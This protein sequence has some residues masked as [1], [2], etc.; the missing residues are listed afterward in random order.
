MLR[1][2]ILFLFCLEIYS[3]SS[4][5][6]YSHGN[7]TPL[8]QYYLEII[9]QTRMKSAP[10]LAF[11]PSLLNA[12]QKHAKDMVENNYLSHTNR[13]RKSPTDRAT[14]EGY[15][16]PV[17][18]N[19]FNY[20]AETSEELWKIHRKIFQDSKV[21]QKN[22]DKLLHLKFNEIGIGIEGKLQNGKIVQK[23]GR[24]YFLVYIT[25]VVYEDKNQNGFYDIGEGLEGV[26]VIP[27]YGEFYGVTSFSGGY[28]IPFYVL[29][30]R[31]ENFPIKTKGSK[32]SQ[33]HKE[34]SESIR[35]AYLEDNSKIEWLEFIVTFSGG[36]LSKSRAVPVKMKK[37]T[38]ILYKLIQ[39]EEIIW[40]CPKDD[41]LILGEN[42][43]LD[44]VLSPITEKN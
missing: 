1:T 29:D 12:A 11:H 19:I 10:P 34:E 31:E 27:E 38:K 40:E 15:L 43:K 5:K 16:Q 28:A 33:A 39:S 9:N 26:N 4:L 25:G 18:E 7:P 3:Q 41:P 20:G 42:I 22:I 32:W 36:R 6:Y 21:Y 44:L 14:E 17:A 8:E 37:P 23:F 35:K 13:K 24:N 2:W 30:I